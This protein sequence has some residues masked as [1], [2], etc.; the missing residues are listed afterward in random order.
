MAVAYVLVLEEVI[1]SVTLTSTALLRLVQLHTLHEL[2]CAKLC[3]GSSGMRLAVD[4]QVGQAY[5]VHQH[6]EH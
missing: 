2:V 5:C 6:A 3:S 1:A 4:E